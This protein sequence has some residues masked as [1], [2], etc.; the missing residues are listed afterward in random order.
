[1]LDTLF[2]NT[3]LR[4]DPFS[5]SGAAAEKHAE[6]TNL[7]LSSG[8]VAISING[9]N[10]TKKGMDVIRRAVSSNHWLLGE[11]KEKKSGK[12][13]YNLLPM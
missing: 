4:S 1:M 10:V 8:L 11:K 2:W 7:V 6:E 13:N 12:E 9:N 3:T 5:I